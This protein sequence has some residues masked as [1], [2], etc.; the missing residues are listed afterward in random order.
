[1][2]ASEII[3]ELQSLIEK[4]GDHHVVREYN[5]ESGDRAMIDS[6]ITSKVDSRAWDYDLRKLGSGQT[7]FE[8][9]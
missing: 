6:I 1:M 9:K 5:N 3:Q 7:V 8:V 4:H 2:L